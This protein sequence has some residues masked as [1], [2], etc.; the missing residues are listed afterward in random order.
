MCLRE[1][2]AKAQL[3]S[4]FCGWPATPQHSPRVSPGCVP[5]I[6]RGEPKEHGPVL[7]HQ[8]GVR[9]QVGC[10]RRRGQ[11]GQAQ[12]GDPVLPEACRMQSGGAGP[13]ATPRPP[14]HPGDARTLGPSLDTAQRPGHWLSLLPFPEAPADSPGGRGLGDP[15]RHPSHSRAASQP[16][17]TQKAGNE[18]ELEEEGAGRTRPPGCGPGGGP[19]GGWGQT[20][21]IPKA[22][23]PWGLTAGRWQSFSSP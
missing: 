9:T 18:K 14:G 1:R 12:C 23:G 8:H 5:T 4:P 22:C 2:R 6:D 13:S 20:G 10:N 21:C 19:G 7:S 17:G 16:L 15:L 11:G 3:S